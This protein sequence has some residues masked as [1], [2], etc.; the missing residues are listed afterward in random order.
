[1]SVGQK[2][3]LLSMLRAGFWSAPFTA[4]LAAAHFIA[5]VLTPARSGP[6]AKPA[7]VI[8][9]PYT[10]V[11]QFIPLDYYW[12]IPG[13]LLAPSFVV[14]MAFIRMYASDEKKILA[15]IGLSFAVIYATI[16]MT[17]YF[18]QWTVVVPSLQKGEIA[19]LSL[20]TQYNPHGIFIVLEALGYLV[21]STAMIFVAPV[22]TGGRL[23]RTLRWLF[24][25]SF[26][27]GVALFVTL[28]LLGYDIVAFEVSILLINWIVL[29]ASG[30][31]LSIL[32][33]RASR[34]RILN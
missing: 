34:N 2:K 6:F 13:F 5:G 27:F 23:E 16:M 19:G 8:P 33:S 14:F 24:V 28:P 15:Q 30:A 18:I 3:P 32:F 26:V 9:Y 7:D 4:L 20:F 12:L 17:N 22:F 1:M 10:S 29:M 31:L 21:M 25:G 11:S